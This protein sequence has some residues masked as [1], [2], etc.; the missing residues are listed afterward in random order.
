MSLSK[1]L[2]KSSVVTLS[3]FIGLAS[4][5]RLV[6][7]GIYVVNYH[8]IADADVD[9]YINQNTYRT[10]NEFEDD[11]KFYL[12]HFRILS[13]AELIECLKIN[14]PTPGNSLLITFDDGLRINYDIQ[15]PILKRYGITASF[16]LT[17]AFID[18]KDLHHGRKLNL[19]MQ[20]L[21]DSQ[22]DSIKKIL[23]G[24]LADHGL[25]K[26]NIDESLSALDYRK[27]H[28]L[29]SIAN[30]M[31]VD[32]TKYLEKHRPY[33]SSSQ[34]NEMLQ[35]GFEFGAHSIDHPRYS[36]LSLEDQ[37]QQTTGSLDYVVNHFKLNYR[38]FAFPYSDDSLSG[39]FFDRIRP[40]V[41][42][43]FGMGG[44]RSGPISFNIQRSDVEST[45]LPI[46]LALKYRLLTS[47]LRSILN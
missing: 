39:E 13:M 41:D 7:P 20:R 6:R 1:N 8:S 40:H 43:T 18:N 37:I 27:K 12:K 30:L 14:T 19:L 28:H 2:A 34:V 24:Y 38:L 47:G 46:E 26:K 16:F 44:F 17:S 36:Q 29:E 9:P 21:S 25:L 23:T 4:L 22:D 33:L 10:A 5:M 3:K 11:L 45:K 31:D 15:Y 35:N 32:F 42:L